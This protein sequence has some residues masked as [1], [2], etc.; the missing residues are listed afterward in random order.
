VITVVI[1]YYQRSPGI[2]RK[3]LASVAA[4][5]G[6]QLPV[7]IIVVDDASPALVEPELADAGL[8]HHSLQVIVQ[9]NGGPGAARNTGLDNASPDTRYIA[10]LDSDDE[11]M[12]D[13]LARAVAALKCG[14]DFYF[15]DHLQ[16]GQTISAF[17]RASRIKINEHPLLPTPTVG[18]HAYQGDMFDQIIRG[19]VIG[20]STV[21]YD[22]ERFRER[23]FYIEFANAGE[24][25]LYWME[26]TARDARIAFSSNVEA[27]YGR[28]VNVYSGSGWGTEQHMLR[29]HNELRYKKTIGRL[30]NVTPTQRR[31][32]HASIGQLREAFA[33]DLLHRL[34]HRKPMSL[35]LLASHFA[36]DPMSYLLLP[37]SALHLLTK[38]A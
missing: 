6:C 24:D 32:I 26:L 30:Y 27:T 5:R 15:A 25:Y 8:M 7:H 18:L 14:Y 17:V 10:F 12:P 38:R 23:R 21:M 20:T 4:Q 1:P 33:R 2:L 13:H 31:H 22:F 34:T 11:W 3:A 35:K 28:G 36:L 16:L 19:N 29:L 9:P 37:S